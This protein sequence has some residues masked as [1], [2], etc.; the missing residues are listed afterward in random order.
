MSYDV[1]SDTSFFVDACRRCRAVQV[2]GSPRA[3][4]RLSQVPW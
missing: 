3:G 2:D 4:P 1:A